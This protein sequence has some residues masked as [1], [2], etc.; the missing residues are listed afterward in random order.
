[1]S[2]PVKSSLRTVELLEF[3]AGHRGMH[4]LGDLQRELG[5]PKSS[6]YMLLRTL[7]DIGW[8]ET[9]PTGTMYGIGVRALLVGTSYLDGDETVAVAREVMDWLAATTTET[10]H[11]ARLDGADVVYLATRESQHYLRPMSRVGRRLPAYAT[12]LGKA[13]L[14]ERTDAEIRALLPAEL[15]PITAHTLPTT[16]ALIADLAATRRRGYAVDSE[17]NVIGLRCFGAALRSRR[18]ARDAISCSVPL[19]RL[20]KG[21]AGEIVAALS[22]ARDRLERALSS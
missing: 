4:T 21:R 9:D 12:S 22:E 7:A 2:Q 14:A 6:L 11:L 8:V 17:E 20:T 10:V 5:Y 16:D 19:A 1:M 15:A 13:L 18:P 3:F